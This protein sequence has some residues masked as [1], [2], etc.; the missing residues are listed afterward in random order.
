[1]FFRKVGDIVSACGSESDSTPN[2]LLTGNVMLDGSGGA[3]T[4]M[5]GKDVAKV[6]PEVSDG[7]KWDAT[8]N[9]FL[10][11]ND[12]LEGPGAEYTEVPGK[13]ED[14]VAPEVSDDP[15]V[16]VLSSSDQI[17]LDGA[18]PESTGWQA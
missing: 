17:W 6:Y 4:E 18:A 16:R 3:Y 15:I 10:T 14:Q 9:W 12:M 5:H 2:W 11:G 8:P 1:M 7:N 13:P